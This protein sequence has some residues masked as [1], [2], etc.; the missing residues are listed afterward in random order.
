MDK[1]MLQADLAHEIGLTPTLHAFLIV[2]Q[3]GDRGG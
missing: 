1:W 2:V 3:S